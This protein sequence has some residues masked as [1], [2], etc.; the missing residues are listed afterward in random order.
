MKTK[1]K[2][3]CVDCLYCKVSKKT[4][5]KRRLCFCSQAQKMGRHNENYWVAKKPCDEFDDMTENPVVLVL[6][7]A[8]MKR[9]PLLRKREYEYV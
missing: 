5:E 8:T 7:V 4:T 2:K 6:P 1:E 9:R 3:T